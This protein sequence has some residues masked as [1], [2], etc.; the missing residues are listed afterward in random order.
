MNYGM[1]CKQFRQQTYGRGK[2]LQSKFSSSWI[3][4]MITEIE[5]L[6]GFVKGTPKIK[7]CSGPPISTKHT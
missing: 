3:D 6:L 2:R 1:T 7:V 4:S 5:W